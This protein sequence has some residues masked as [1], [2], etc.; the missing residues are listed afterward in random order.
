MPD[1][2]VVIDMQV[3]SFGADCLPRYDFSGLERLN[4]QPHWVRVSAITNP[5]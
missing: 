4:A 5:E 2:L 3:G 1:T